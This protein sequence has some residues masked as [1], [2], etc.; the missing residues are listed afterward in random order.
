MPAPSLSIACEW[1]TYALGAEI[2][3]RAGWAVVPVLLIIICSKFQR[4][5]HN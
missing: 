3:V 4:A 1:S 5:K 2:F